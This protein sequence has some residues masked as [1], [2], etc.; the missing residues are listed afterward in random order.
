MLDLVVTGLQVEDT[1]THKSI[2]VEEMRV[3]IFTQKASIT[4]DFQNKS[5]NHHVWYLECSEHDPM[6][7]VLH[8]GVH[9]VLDQADL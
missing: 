6:L 4:F 9:Q 3:K 1:H 2:F 5:L 7:P 8:A